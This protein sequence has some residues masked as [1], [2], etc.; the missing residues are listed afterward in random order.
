MATSRDSGL[1]QEIPEKCG[2]QLGKRKTPS[3]SKTFMKQRRGM[4]HQQLAYVHGMT[5]YRVHTPLYQ[6]KKRKY[7]EDLQGRDKWYAP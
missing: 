2:L 1:I 7:Q 3:F 6:F 4:L 5:Q